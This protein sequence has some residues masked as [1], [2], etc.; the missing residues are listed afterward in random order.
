MGLDEEERGHCEGIVGSAV[1]T[2]GSKGGRETS[3]RSLK[4]D[5][6]NLCS[7]GQEG[8]KSCEEEHSIIAIT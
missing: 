3:P 1:G 8:E 6:I 7:A 2:Y 5:Q 4:S